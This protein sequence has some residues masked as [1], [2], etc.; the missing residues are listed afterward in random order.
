MQLAFE[1]SGSGSPLVLVHGIGSRRGAW[2]PVVPHLAGEREVL[3]VD[4]P[5]F[6]DSPPLPDR[7][8]PFVSALTEALVAWWTELGIERPH[9]A[10]NS[11]GGGIALELARAGAVRSATALSPIGF[12][13]PLEARY[14][15]LMLR[16]TRL[17]CQRARSPMTRMARSR[18]GRAALLG[19]MFGR[20]GRRDPAAAADDIAALAA[21]PGWEATLPCTTRYRFIRGEEL[22]V[23]VTIGWGTRDRLLI[24]R[25]AERARAALPQGRHVPLPRCGHV[26]MSDDPEGIAQL[27]LVASA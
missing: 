24:P 12:G 7:V 11:L 25:Q 20:P 15:A 2:D 27:L 17:L 4:L 16:A 22:T 3:A 8:A 26:P 23:P 13:T 19:L 1:R 6:G 21:A 10:G 14:G 5:G 9:V 18:P